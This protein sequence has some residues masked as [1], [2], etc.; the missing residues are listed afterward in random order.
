MEEAVFICC[1]LYYRI[2]YMYFIF[3]NYRANERPRI[4]RVY[5]M[6]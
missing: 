3:G 1:R 5:K 2:Y 4:L 6:I